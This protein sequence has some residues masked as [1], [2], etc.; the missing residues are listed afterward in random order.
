MPLGALIIA[1]YVVMG[2]MVLLLIV[3]L[4]AWVVDRGEA[5]RGPIRK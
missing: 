5:W 1:L 4:L 3:A 2:V